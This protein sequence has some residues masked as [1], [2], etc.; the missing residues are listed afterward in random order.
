[1][2][3]VVQLVGNGDN[4]SLFFKEP[5][6]GMKLTCNLP[7]FNVAGTYASVIVD[8]KMMKAMQEGSIQVPGEWILGMRP[9]IHMEKNPTFYMRHSHQIKE[10]YTVLPEYVA[11]YTDFNCGHM[12]THYA[13][14]KVKADEIHLYG[15]DSIF[16]FNLRSCSDFYLGSD[17]GNQ[18]NNRLANN[19][20]PVW[21]NMFK[22]FP[23]TKFFL[24]HMHDAIKINIGNNVEIVTYD[25]KAQV[26]QNT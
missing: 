5:R 23:N 22:E 15:F 17:R 24:H 21:E 25:S 16:D 3:R 2:K 26:P 14:N 6:P 11:N 18:N 19:W 13:A 7:P 12:A 9:K 4:A 8:F 10:F 1:M 20:R